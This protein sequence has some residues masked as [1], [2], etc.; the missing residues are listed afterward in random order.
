[1]QSRGAKISY[2]GEVPRLISSYEPVKIDDLDPFLDDEGILQVRG[3]LR[4]AECSESFR[5]PLYVFP[6]I[7]TSPH[8][9]ID[10]QALSCAS[11]TS[12]SRLDY[13]RNSVQWILDNWL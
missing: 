4:R 2:N 1:M 13:Q 12:R 9:K 5:H 10:S 11:R 3:R 6:Q 8:H 7:K